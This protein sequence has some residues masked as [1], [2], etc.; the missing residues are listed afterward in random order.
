VFSLKNSSIALFL[1]HHE[2]SHVLILLLITSQTLN[3]FV[4][5]DFIVI[6]SKRVVPHHYLDPASKQHLVSHHHEDSAW[7]ACL[8][9]WIALTKH[10]VSTCMARDVLLLKP[11]FWLACALRAVL[12]QMSLCHHIFSTKF[13]F[14]VWNQSQPVTHA[15]LTGM[16]CTGLRSGCRKDGDR[17]RCQCLSQSLCDSSFRETVL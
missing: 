3:D 10:P 16:T 1:L 6:A 14:K 4:C 8:S 13:V 5:F 7:I 15:I 9:V 17:S 12:A 2:S 11:V